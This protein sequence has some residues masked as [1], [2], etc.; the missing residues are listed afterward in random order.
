[1]TPHMEQYGSTDN[2]HL[3]RPGPPHLGRLQLRRTA[4]SA[5]QLAAHQ[6]AAA[7]RRRQAVVHVH[8]LR[9]PARHH[10]LQHRR[11]GRERAGHRQAAPARRPRAGAC[12]LQGDVGRADSRQPAPAVRCAGPTER[13]CRVRP[14]LGLHPGRHPARGC[15]L[16]ALRRPHQLHPCSNIDLCRSRGTAAELD[17]TEPCRA[18]RSWFTP[19]TTARWPART[20][21]AA[22]GPLPTPRPT[23]CRST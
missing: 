3:R 14:Y 12:A 7:E 22:R 15:A 20:D 9:E 2:F 17:G 5:T 4:C 11:A 23:T 18:A 1:M 6:G 10:V 16:E 13:A 19:P 8:E 21:C